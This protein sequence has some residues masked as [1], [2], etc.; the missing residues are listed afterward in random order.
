MSQQD[1]RGAL[2]AQLMTLGWEDQTA[3]EDRA[4]S[5]TTGVPYQVVNTLFAEPNSYGLGPGAM[6][7][8]LFQVRLMYPV[9]SGVAVSGARAEEI[10]AAFPKNLHLG[11]AKIMR[12]PEITRLG[13]EADRDITIV[14]IRFS[15]R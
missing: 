15:E 13:P 14:R 8:G 11:A 4:F 6:E 10:Q 12:K 9:N 1:I 2:Q 7:R 3:W 5:P